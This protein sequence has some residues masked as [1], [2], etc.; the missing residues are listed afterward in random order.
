VRGSDCDILCT[1]DKPNAPRKGS[2]LKGTAILKRILGLVG[3]SRRLGNSELF[4]KEISRHLPD[5]HVLSLIRLP[6]LDIKPCQA[7]YSCIM[8]EPCP[9]NDHMEFLRDQVL[10]S[11]GLII[12]APVYFA[13]A[14]SI[15]KRILDRGFLFYSD[16]KQNEHKPCILVNLH[17]IEEKI[18]VAPQAL[19]A[20]AAVLCLDVKASVNL[21][22]A[23]PGEVLADPANI[24]L[25][26]QLGHLLFSTRSEKSLDGCPFCGCEIVRMRNGEFVCTLCYGCF[27][28][29]AKAKPMKGTAGWEIGTV[30]FIHE[31]SAWLRGM[32]DTYM[33]NRKALLRLS[34]PY[35]DIGTWVEP[36][37]ISD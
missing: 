23:L 14:H 30:Q 12:A 11:D 37:K 4:I 3:S 32:R 5:E 20:L 34:L 15:I 21:R 10:K 6:A 2:S 28:L 36:P 25:A 24:G 1:G 17:G 35:K 26:G 19:R 31:H 8:G 33:E 18:G 9:I 16:A 29:D 13:G 22:A 7:C 27:T